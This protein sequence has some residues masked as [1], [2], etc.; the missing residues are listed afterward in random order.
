MIQKSE[1]DYIA[2]YVR[3]KHPEILQS[4]D[5]LCWK[6]GHVLSDALKTATDAIVGLFKGL[7]VDDI[8][9]LKEEQEGGSVKSVEEMR[10]EYENMMENYQAAKERGDYEG[11]LQWYE[12][13]QTCWEPEGS[14]EE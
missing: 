11:A 7:S 2:E 1:N 10:E 9:E 12:K 5:F 3:E 13:A 6:A 4:L 14:G 8:K